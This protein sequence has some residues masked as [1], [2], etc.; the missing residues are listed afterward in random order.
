MQALPDAARGEDPIKTTDVHRR[1]SGFLVDLP[2]VKT[3]QRRLERLEGD[4]LV[5]SKKKGSALYWRKLPGASGLAARAAGVMSHDEA[6]ALQTLRRFSSRQIPSLVAETLSPLFDVAGKRLAA[7]NTEGERRYRKWIDKVEVESGNFSLQYP[8]VE[9]E[10]FEVVSRALFYE[11][12]LE[13]VYQPRTNVDNNKA[14]VVYPLGLVE[15]S[16]LVYLVASMPRYPNP[17][18][19]RL[20]RMS[21]AAMLPNPFAYPRGFRLSAYVRE[22]RQF[23]FMVEGDIFVKLRF[24]NGAGNHLLEA[25]LSSDQEVTQADSGLDVC[26]TVLLSQRLRWWLRAFGPNVEVLAP[27]SLRD[28]L[29]REAQALAAMYRKNAG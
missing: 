11:Q 5:E 12:Q 4:G 22:Q 26:G 15:V 28:E 1:L 13:V 19:Y 2:V 16:G 23:D 3:V 29:A 6:L 9:A 25:P 27:A 10:I 21:H 17:A 24:R 20:D 7:V 8:V 14:K 18:L